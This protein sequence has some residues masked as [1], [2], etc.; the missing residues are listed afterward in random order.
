MRPWPVDAMEVKF[1]AGESGIRFDGRQFRPFRDRPASTRP[2]TTVDR[3]LWNVSQDRHDVNIAKLT[4][5]RP[6][7]VD[8]M[9]V[10]FRAGES[11]I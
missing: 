9:E 7:P 11:G 3:P 5:T 4:P 6:W 1:R 2:Q 8:D 10:K